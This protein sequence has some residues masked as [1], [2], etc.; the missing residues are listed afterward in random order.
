MRATGPFDVKMT[1]ETLVAPDAARARFALDKKYLGPLEA[2]GVGEMLSGGDPSSGNAAY[3][4][5]ETVTGTL[6]GRSG[7]FLLVHRGLMDGGQNRLEILVVP[8]SGKEE[9]VGL[10][11]TMTIEFGPGGAHTYVLDYE[12]E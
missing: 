4:A 10:R 7:S 2:V 8:G 1:P 6:E 12:L 3:V 5:V 11:G 9:L